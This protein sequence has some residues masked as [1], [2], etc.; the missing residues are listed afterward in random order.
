MDSRKNP[1]RKMRRDLYIYQ[2]KDG[3]GDTTEVSPFA[4]IVV[5]I[6]FLLLCILG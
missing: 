6:F 4:F 5:A 1:E 2:F 3:Y